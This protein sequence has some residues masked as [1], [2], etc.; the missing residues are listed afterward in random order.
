M[1][2]CLRLAVVCF[3]CA[4]GFA[5]SSNAA[6]PLQ[7]RIDAL[8]ANGGGTLT[9]TAGVYRTGALFF[10]PGVN[11]RLE[12]GATI[13]GV[14]EAEGYPMRETRI[15]GETCLYYPA[16]VN[17]DGCDGFT[18]SGEGTIDG[19]GANT[20][21]E[22]WTKRAEARKNGG[23]FRN[24]DL[25][26]PRVLY[27]S[28]SKNVEISG[29]TFKNSKFWTTHFYDCEDVLVHDC[30]ILADVLK[31]A[32]GKELKGPST[33][34]IDIDKCRRFTVRNVD[35]SVNDDGVV[36]KGG[37]GA[38]ADDYAKFPGNGP[39]TD[40]LVENCTFRY[41]THSALTLGSECPA[42]TNVTM[43]GCTMDGCGN[44]INLKMRTDTPQHYAN[45]LVENCRG[46]CT[47]FFHV[48]SWSQYH[49]G[50]GRSA[51]ELKSYA[52]GV[53][54]RNN[55]I[56]ASRI[57]DMKRNDKVF[58]ITNL[59]FENN[60]FQQVSTGL[61]LKH[62]GY[63][64][65]KRGTGNGEWGMGNGELGTGNGE[66]GMGN[67]V[68]KAQTRRAFLYADYE[69]SRWMN[70]PSYPF[71]R[72]PHFKFRALDVSRSPESLSEWIAATGANAVY[73]KRGR[74]DKRLLRECAAL[75]I[76]AYGF[77]YGCDAAKWNRGRYDAFVAA[78]PTA[79]G[80][81]P[82]K[83]W[84]K[85]T[86]CPSDPATADFFAQTIRE[87]A[88]AP[89]AGV[90]VCLWDDYG[91]NC[92]C[93]RCKANG[94]ANNWGRQVAVAV[95]AWERAV[96]SLGKEL[97]VRTWASGASHWLGDEWVHAPGYGGESGEPLS[98]WGEAMKSAGPGVRFQ[99]KVYN[100]DCQPAPPF[101]ALLPVAP[102]RE[103]A[104][105][106]ITGQ[107][108]GLQYLPASVVDQTARQMRRVAEL[109]SPEGGVMLYAGTYKR[110]GYRALSDDLNSVNYHVWRQLSWNPNDDV[111][112]LWREWAVPRHGKDAEAVIAA[113]KAT[114][115]ASVAAFSPLGLG[116]PTESFFAGS[117]E[118][119]E[120]LLRYTNRFFLPE[121]I[122]AL[123][124]TK[125]NI[126][127]VVKEKN[128]A[129]AA[130]VGRD[131]PIAPQRFDWLRAQLVVTRALDGALWRYFYLRELAK[132]GRTDAD[133]LSE[134]D[135]DFDVVARHGAEVCPG[136]GR[137]FALMRDIRDKAH[138][139]VG[140]V[141]GVETKTNR[142]EKI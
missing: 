73:L 109:V 74:P 25:M 99:T 75:D 19:H 51:A 15:E 120:S 56:E 106:Q 32:N 16:L 21:E 60:V 34:A 138:A 59:T 53:T 14:D 58:E 122:A 43:R 84:E 92:V 86:L 67:F 66:W 68:V 42:A 107:T 87:I 115:R 121:G 22:F 48:Q 77:L 33:D 36:V 125:E 54:L 119:R 83:S 38:W 130:L 103:I 102:R 31:D 79:K 78:H 95:K 117:V 18:I 64:V 135:A 6:W 40:V 131:D 62:D 69:K 71:I 114:E 127:R 126:A 65:E 17:A 26:R 39:T 11:L 23:D 61:P 50:K 133:V 81:G 72:D 123:A 116:A 47:A 3:L 118:R 5:G 29:V 9:L 108:V 30:A 27:V 98:V 20:W 129:L 101:S 136:L 49:D 52:D 90:V 110:D 8:A 94:L 124:P 55:V 112:A 2:R 44:M 1:K 13:L 57:N 24:K 142:K 46:T 10:K 132:D 63:V 111:E 89:V 139:L 137:P 104:E 37:K 134:I 141:P 88:E 7:T 41:P 113:M 45:V 35:I 70:A 85:G 128:D 105:W 76:P 12:K 140:H 97:I 28:N 4:V 91:L 96:S 80:T 100:S 93:A 82:A